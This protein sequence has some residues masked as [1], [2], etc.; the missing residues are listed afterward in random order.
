MLGAATP[1]PT[2]E[3]PSPRLEQDSQDRTALE[4]RESQPQTVTLTGQSARNLLD[5]HL[6]LVAK[7]NQDASGKRR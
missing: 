4:N 3:G 7:S 5:S 6:P 2:T 1:V